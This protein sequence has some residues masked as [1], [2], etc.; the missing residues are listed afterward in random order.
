MKSV[1]GG[2]KVKFQYL[3]TVKLNDKKVRMVLPIATN[4]LDLYN[5]AILLASL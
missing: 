2:E 4:Y 3:Q 1:G 5:A